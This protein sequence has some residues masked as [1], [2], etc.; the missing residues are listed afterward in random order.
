MPNYSITEPHPTVA[1]STWCHA[2]R[3]GAGNFFKAPKA[4]TSPSGVPTPITQTISNSTTATNKF[5]SGR[6][7]AGNAHS[8]IERPVMSFEAEYERKE[9]T[10]SVTRPAFT[11]RG[12]AGN[13]KSA[14][15]KQSRKGSDAST[16][17]NAS[18]KSGSSTRSGF[19]GRLS[20]SLSNRQ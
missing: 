3:G 14:S 1:A 17:S 10:E 8:S 19:M 4:V 18:T 7:G 6:G 16:I 12:G 20:A 15:S 9:R 13:F 2:G 11:G 5:H